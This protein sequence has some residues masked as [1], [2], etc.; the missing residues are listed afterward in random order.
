MKRARNCV[1]FVKKLCCFR[2]ISCFCTGFP[3]CTLDMRNRWSSANC[4][5]IVQ[6]FKENA[7]WQCKIIIFAPSLMCYEK[8]QTAKMHDSSAM[9]LQSFKTT[10]T[11]LRQHKGERPEY[12]GWCHH[13]FFRGFPIGQNSL[14][15]NEW[16]LSDVFGA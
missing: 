6:F 5:A 14:T 1:F 10:N 3:F 2:K 11:D 13:P 7:L 12:D 9:G 8:K 16:H 15:S 4:T